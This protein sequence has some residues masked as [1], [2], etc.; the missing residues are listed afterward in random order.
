MP[1]HQRATSHYLPG[2][3]AFLAVSILTLAAVL[4]RIEHRRE[5]ELS[6]RAA[7]T[8][9]DSDAKKAA[10]TPAT[11]TSN[12]AL[13]TSQERSLSTDHGYD[14]CLALPQSP[15]RRKQR[16]R[17]EERS[18]RNAE[19]AATSGPTGAFKSALREPINRAGSLSGMHRHRS[20][21]QCPPAM[22][23][24]GTTKLQQQQKIQRRYHVQQ[25]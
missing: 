10:A 21:V 5:R 24:S 22:F 3:V 6:G 17:Y 16:Q 11:S 18:C 15:S 23:R 13:K 2:A 7:A 1:S 14:Y 4:T 20:L 12:G 25:Q 9:G 19:S 8:D